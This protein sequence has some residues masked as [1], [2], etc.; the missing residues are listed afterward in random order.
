MYDARVAKVFMPCFILRLLHDVSRWHV[1]R[2]VW[3]P[4]S[5]YAHVPKYVFWSGWSVCSQLR[6]HALFRD[7]SINTQLFASH[8]IS[9]MKV[10]QS[11]V[12]ALSA[13][14]TVSGFSAINHAAGATS[15][16]LNTLSGDVA[17]ASYSAPA[18]PAP[19]APAAPA[20]A[21]PAAAAPSYAAP[22]AAGPA[23]DGTGR[24]GYLEV[25]ADA[26]APGRAM[27]GSSTGE[28]VYLGSIVGDGRTMFG[29]NTGDS[30]YL[31]S[32]VG[33]GRTMFGSST[34]ESAYLS[35]ISQ[36]STSKTNCP[37][38]SQHERTWNAF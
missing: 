33:A 4:R 24:T 7:H 16:Y 21:P 2:Y 8:L 37:T 14:S 35:S 12:I 5:S 25:I 18:A 23:V 11:A 28:S 22:A 17:P 34:G 27:F 32:I 1:C 3:R 26:G 19:A 29:S 36:W 6:L 20:W 13:I 31:N 38:M 15:S 9:T 10:F 30:L